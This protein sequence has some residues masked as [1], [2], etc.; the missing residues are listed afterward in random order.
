MTRKDLTDMISNQSVTNGFVVL[1]KE[2][3]ASGH[4][5]YTI[6]DAQGTITSGLSFAKVAKILGGEVVKVTEGGAKKKETASG[7]DTARILKLEVSTPTEL[8]NKVVDTL[9]TD[10]K[11]METYLAKVA[12]DLLNNYQHLAAR[13]IDTIAVQMYDVFSKSANERKAK[14]LAY[15]RAREEKEAA[16]AREKRNTDLAHRRQVLLDYIKQYDAKVGA[17]FISGNAEKAQMLA[18]QKDARVARANDIINSINI[19]IEE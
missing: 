13:C 9:V 2:R 1:S 10:C 12:P 11:R 16:E 4:Y 3:D 6:K 19:L 7:S 8:T 5:T 14:A 15:I 17:A 18:I